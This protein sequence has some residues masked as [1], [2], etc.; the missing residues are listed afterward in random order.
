MLPSEQISSLPDNG[1]SSEPLSRKQFLRRTAAVAGGLAGLSLLDWSPALAA[2][3]SGDREHHHGL[4]APKPIPGGFGPDFTTL[5]P[6]DPFIHV[7][8]PAVGVEMSTITDFNGIVAAGEVQGTAQGSDA[9]SYWFDADMRFMSG[10]YVDD[11]G[12]RR[13]HAFG[14]V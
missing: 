7:L 9:S 12:R 4:G 3:E 8:P 6:S 11:Q 13:E 1:G 5:L 14:F 2:A 10:D